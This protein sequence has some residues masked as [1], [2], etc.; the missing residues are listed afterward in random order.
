[1][2]AV[3]SGGV[4]FFK[5]NRVGKSPKLCYVGR[6]NL[7]YYFH[8]FTRQ[9]LPL[10]MAK[11]YFGLLGDTKMLHRTDRISSLLLTINEV[12]PYFTH[13][14][15]DFRSSVSLPED[16][17]IDS[18]LLRVFH[19]VQNHLLQRDPTQVLH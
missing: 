5:R 12:F 3:C 14:T 13:H 11:T 15:F 9:K 10:R 16:F 6:R 7:N 1:M 17:N 8:E 18:Y 2:S 19:G 4:E